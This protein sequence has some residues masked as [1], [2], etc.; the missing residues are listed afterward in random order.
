VLAQVTLK[1][2]KDD[3]KMDAIAHFHMR[4]DFNINGPRDF[5]FFNFKLVLPLHIVTTKEF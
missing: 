5:N 1:I 3:I 4:L 2:N